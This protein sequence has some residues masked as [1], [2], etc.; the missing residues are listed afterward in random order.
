MFGAE[1]PAERGALIS[2][3]LFLPTT[4][5]NPALYYKMSISTACIGT[6][7]STCRSVSSAGM[8]NVFATPRSRKSTSVA[9]TK[10]EVRQGSAVYDGWKAE[11]D[12]RIHVYPESVES[13]LD[14]FVPSAQPYTLTDNLTGAFSQYKPAKGKEVQGYPGL[15]R[16]H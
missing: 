16:H 13:F 1:F 12:Q 4:P 15:V 9:N 11:L 3:P 10:K 8:A 6:S 5:S 7:R 2:R 14:T